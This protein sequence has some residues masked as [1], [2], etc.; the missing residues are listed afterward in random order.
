MTQKVIMAAILVQLFYLHLSEFFPATVN[1]KV[2]KY[3]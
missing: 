1:V 3:S 2:T